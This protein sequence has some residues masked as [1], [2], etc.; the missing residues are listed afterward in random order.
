[1]ISYIFITILCLLPYASRL[2]WRSI[3]IDTEQMINTPRRILTSW[4]YHERPG[5]VFSKYLFGQTTFHYEIE[6][7]F[8][9]LFLISACL[10][11]RRFLRKQ[12]KGA[13]WIFPVLFLT[14]PSMTEQLH[15][16]LQSMEV[17][18]ALF[19]CLMA[20]G[21]ISVSLEDLA[22][23][24][25][26]LHG[27]RY[28]K[29]VGLLVLGSAAMVWSF[30]SYQALVA[31]YI[32]AAA[33]LYLQFYS[34]KTE[35][36]GTDGSTAGETGI[37]HPYQSGHTIFNGSVGWWRLAVSHVLVFA[38]GFLLSQLA[39]KI[40]L[41]R[42]TGS[43]HSTAYVAGMVKWGTQPVLQCLKD[44]YHYGVGIL[45]GQGHFCTIAY[46]AALAG[47]LVIT[48][49]RFSRDRHRPGYAVCLLAGVV[50][51]LSPFLLPLYAGGPDQVRAR[52]ALAFVTAFGWYYLIGQ[53]KE[54][55]KGVM[56]S[57]VGESF[58][59]CPHSIICLAAVII[60]CVFGVLQY[61]QTV[62][63]TYTA[64]QVY[65]QECRL[66]DEIAE[67]IALTGA[68]EDAAVQFV[69]SWE[70]EITEGMVRG[71]TIGYSFY[72]WDQEMASGSTER[73]LGLWETLGYEYCLI[74]SEMAPAGEAAA[75]AMPCWPEE[76]SVMWDGVTVI[77]KL[78]E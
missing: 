35:S 32:A 16:L 59:G 68:P 31:L 17:A 5:L 37:G 60:A 19:L 14:H 7:L 43:F 66:T 6:I 50:L 23:R 78:C 9:V 72:E 10:L 55:S 70:P 71:E 8:T 25:K 75:E 62:R 73:I 46:T 33:A 53:L 39:A 1:M 22:A 57:A 4:L 54:V 41:Y 28:G 42:S 29:N 63:L 20:A 13:E 64:H 48:I 38:V 2:I 49:L 51:Y 69:G 76:G 11:W 18:W 15:F 77:V 30:S 44:L 12:Q 24:E 3:S 74:D 65:M 36:Q 47:T 56:K 21:L 58:T 40:G 26:T 45:T 61:G 52:L 67:R 34:R 27:S